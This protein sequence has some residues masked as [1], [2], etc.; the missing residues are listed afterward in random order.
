MPTPIPISKYKDVAVL[1]WTLYENNPQIKFPPLPRKF[2]QLPPHDLRKLVDQA[3]DVIGAQPRLVVSDFVLQF[4]GFNP[5]LVMQKQMPA[6]AA[7]S[8]GAAAVVTAESADV[9]L[10]GVSWLD[11]SLG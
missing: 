7:K 1:C 8:T 10:F 5:H 9:D 11:L 2:T 4:L 3:F 6:A